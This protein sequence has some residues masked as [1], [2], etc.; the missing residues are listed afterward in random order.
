[1]RTVTTNPAAII[2]TAGILFFSS[3][4]V[5]ASDRVEV[6]GDIL[7][8]VLPAAAAGMTVYKND[9]K[10]TFQF[11]E[12][13]LVNGC[14][15][16]ILKYT[17]KE[18]R[19]NGSDNLSFPSSHTSFS[20]VSAEFLYRRYGL[21]YGIPAFAVA[22]FVGYSRIESKHH[23]LHDVLAGAAIGIVSAYIFTKLYSNMRVQPLTDGRYFGVQC[24]GAF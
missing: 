6:A 17:V 19:P 8:V 14:A 3:T 2:F 23:Y 9:W 21:H 11:G 1:M 10:G 7:A 16:G 12:S 4:S 22:A 13:I 5:S 15:T 20:C 24:S 18:R